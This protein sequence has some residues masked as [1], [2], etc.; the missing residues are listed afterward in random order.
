M[1]V[2]S[3][4]YS[5]AGWTLELPADPSPS[6]PPLLLLP[7]RRPA[8]QVRVLVGG[9]DYYESPFN[10]AV[11]ARRPPGST[12][13]PLV[14]LAALAEGWTAEDLLRDEPLTANEAGGFQPANY[15]REFGGTVTVEE[16][17]VRSL[18]IPTVRL[19][20][21]IGVDK[22][23]EMARALGI[24]TEL[25]RNLG[26]SLGAG[27]LTPLEMAAAYANIASGGIRS[28]PHLILRVEAHDGR[29]LE[30]AS[31]RRTRAVPAAAVSQLQHMLS[32]V[33]DHGTGRAAAFGRPA[34]GKTGTSDGHRDAWFAGFTP[35]LASVVWLGYDDNSPVGGAFPGTGSSHAAPVWQLFMAAVHANLPVKQFDAAPAPSKKR[36]GGG[37][38]TKQKEKEVRAPLGGQPEGWDLAHAHSRLLPGFVILLR[39]VL[40]HPRVAPLPHFLLCQVT[41]PAK[42]AAP[43]LASVGQAAAASSSSPLLFPTMTMTPRAGGQ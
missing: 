41:P 42:D 21:A 8:C 32:A 15:D 28:R 17:L 11:Q 22:V 3:R 38:R 16:A 43:V 9:R 1:L 34:A 23:I 35:D 36:G 4:G 6:D 37:G 10:R 26:L 31:V 33:I 19:C 25:P 39:C 7:P 24:R 2:G 30:Q 40:S 18:N 29:V 27:E 20:M 14:Y 5:I 12:F 13:K